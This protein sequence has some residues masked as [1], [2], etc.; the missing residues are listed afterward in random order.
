[1]ETEIDYTINQ[2]VLIDIYKTLPNK[3]SQIH[4]FSRIQRTFSKMNQMSGH[5]TN[6]NNFLKLHKQVVQIY[7]TTTS[8]ITK[9][10]PS[11]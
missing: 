4:F 5:K 2:L 9:L 8:I 1:M 6:P 7:R 3:N 10:S 11:S